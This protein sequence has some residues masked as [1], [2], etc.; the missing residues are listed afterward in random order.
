[1][2]INK[3]VPLLHSLVTI[4]QIFFFKMRHGRFLNLDKQLRSIQ[5]GSGIPFFTATP[6]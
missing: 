1:M 4:A 5:K 2:S 3:Q 6:E